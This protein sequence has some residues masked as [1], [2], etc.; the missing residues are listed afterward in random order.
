MQSGNSIY[1]NCALTATMHGRQPS[2]I[3]VT[4][5]PAPHVYGNVVINSTLM[6][7]GL[8]CLLERFDPAG[9][10]EAMITHAATMF[11]GVP[12]M[13]A[14]ML[15]SEDVSAITSL[16]RCTVG[17]QTIPTSTIEEWERRTGAPLL[18]LWGMTE[19]SGL[20]TTH[21]IHAPSVPG[22]IGV[23]L[24]GIEA[25]IA[26][27]GD[28]SLTMP[29]GVAGELVIRG[30]LVMMGYFGNPEATAEVITDDGWLRT[31]DIAYASGSGH[32]FVV[33][34]LKDVILTGGYNVYPAEIERV[35]ATHA[36]VAQVA[37]GRAPDP[38]KGELARA[39]VV[40]RSGAEATE[41]AL[42]EHCRGQLA[43]YKLP[44]SV[45]FVAALPTTS[46]GKVV[47]RRLSELDAGA[48]PQCE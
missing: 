16:T 4:A 31:G 19:L 27:P 45:C 37:V 6:T 43:A 9:A 22:S 1:L 38:V 24:P 35:V 47:R 2:D 28:T 21:T 39:Y 17:G 30:P 32:Y 3:V 40:L 13:Y 33:D 15:A 5:L 8:V 46:S 36:A 12:A 42:I 7:G 14:T 29:T 26:D 20:G 10:V 34:R 18:E 41:E 25:R 11:E 48:E 23:T 44:R